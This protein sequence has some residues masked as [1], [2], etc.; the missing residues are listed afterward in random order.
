MPLIKLSHNQQICLGGWEFI[1]GKRGDIINVPESTA[2]Y[3]LSNGQA[4]AQADNGEWELTTRGKKHLKFLD[5]DG[6]WKQVYY[7]L[8]V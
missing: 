3:L 6:K 7:N 1:S 4:M 2:Y 5:E 8:P